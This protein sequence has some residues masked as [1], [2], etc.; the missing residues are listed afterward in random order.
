ME[1]MIVP[2]LQRLMKQIDELDGQTPAG[3]LKIPRNRVGVSLGFRRTELGSVLVFGFQELLFEFL[4][5]FFSL[6][7]F[8][9][10]LN[11]IRLESLI[12]RQ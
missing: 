11:L 8:F 12:L 10:H 7:V 4:I 1:E 2:A 3:S 6:G 5:Q 9:D